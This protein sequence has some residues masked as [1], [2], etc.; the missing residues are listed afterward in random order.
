MSLLLTAIIIAASAATLILYWNYQ[1]DLAKIST[2]FG[3]DTIGSVVWNGTKFVVFGSDADSVAGPRTASSADGVTWTFPTRTA[4]YSSASLTNG[5]TV[6]WSGSVFC[7]VIGT[8]ALVSSDGIAWT[9]YQVFPTTVNAIIWNG[10]KFLVVG[11]YSYVADSVDGVN[12]TTRRSVNVANPN[13]LAV[14]WSGTQFCVTGT[15]GHSSTSPDGITWT[16]RGLSSTAWGAV[17]GTFLVWSGTRFLVIATTR[18]VASSVDGITWVDNWGNLSVTL[19]NTGT[20]SGV[21]VLNG[22]VYAM[23]AEGKLL[24]STDSGS[25]WTGVAGLFPILWNNSSGNATALNDLAWSGSKY[26]AVGVDGRVATSPDAVTWTAQPD[27]SKYTTCFG[28]ATVGYLDWNG[29]VICA[30]GNSRKIA[31]SPDG[32]T[33]TYRYNCLAGTTVPANAN[34]LRLAVAGSKFCLIMQPISVAPKCVTSTDGIT[35][36]EQ[37]S[38]A[39]AFSSTCYDLIWTGTKFYAVGISAKAA[40]SPDGI[41]WTSQ[42][43]LATAFGVTSAF[44]VAWNGSVFCVAGASGKVATSP[45]GVTWTANTGLSSTAW[46]TSTCDEIAWSG[47]VFCVLNSSGKCAVSSDG[48]TWTYVSQ[49][50]SLGLTFLRLRYL[51]GM[52]Y[53]F[54]SSALNSTSQIYVSY[55]GVNWIQQKKV[56]DTGWVGGVNDGVW[57]G[58]KLV[59]AGNYGS[60]ATLQ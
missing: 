59:I 50:A 44:C 8:Y 53:A 37:A 22:R 23:T 11:N 12:W 45:D 3:E 18:G 52:F 25:S 60:I 41:T 4:K 19:S 55:D 1:P 51:N 42:P 43:G 28:K 35:W 27:L 24:Y 5:K 49:L 56:S 6:A 7:V 31:T 46:G 26:C 2:V 38:F 10:S 33:W 36:T 30:A 29:S 57:T 13:G 9:R 16:N 39:T 14:A 34:A 40:S 20:I 47:S 48:V 54:V 17:S 21:K 15:L 32:I 58:S